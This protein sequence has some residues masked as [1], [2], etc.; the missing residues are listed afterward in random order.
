MN[1]HSTMQILWSI[2]RTK[3]NSSNHIADAANGD[4][5]STAESP[6]RVTSGVVDL[7]SH[8]CGD[9]GY[10]APSNQEDV[11]ALYTGDSHEGQ[12]T[13]ADKRLECVVGE[14]KVSDAWETDHLT[15]LQHYLSY[16]TVTC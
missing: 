15:N 14:N 6:R 9:L 2:L 16:K 4:R 7:L 12:Q 13:Q 5:D 3:D 11:K 10:R 1:E 8:S